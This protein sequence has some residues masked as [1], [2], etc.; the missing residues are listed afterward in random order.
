MT[1]FVKPPRGGFYV[2]L[3]WLITQLYKCTPS[4]HRAWKSSYEQTLKD[5]EREY[6]K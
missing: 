6:P 5:Y 4:G 1:R 2:K 3:G